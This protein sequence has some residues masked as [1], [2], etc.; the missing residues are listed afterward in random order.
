M[1]ASRHLEQNL[2][3]FQE[4]IRLKGKKKRIEQE[5]FIIYHHFKRRYICLVAQPK[6]VN[7]L[8]MMTML[9]SIANSFIVT[10]DIQS[11]KKNITHKE[12]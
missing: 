8:C 11:T 3:R 1:Q 9:L 2:F 7:L 10:L 6:S 12:I 4:K 5:L